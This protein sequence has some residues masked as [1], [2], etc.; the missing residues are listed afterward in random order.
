MRDQWYGGVGP[1]I[2]YGRMA[3]G[4]NGVAGIDIDRLMTK[5]KKTKEDTGAGDII[6]MVWRERYFT[7]AKHVVYRT[8]L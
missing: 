4:G 7:V 6:A 3:N 8:L 1:S 5:S 2:F